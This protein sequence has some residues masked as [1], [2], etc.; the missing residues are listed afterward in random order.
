MNTR[1]VPVICAW[2]NRQY[3]TKTDYWPDDAKL[4]HGIC[5]ACKEKHFSIKTVSDA[6]NASAVSR[7]REILERHGWNVSIL[8]NVFVAN[9]NR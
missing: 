8:E 4:T 3:E 1:I 7:A 5:P 9:R 2:C 6:L